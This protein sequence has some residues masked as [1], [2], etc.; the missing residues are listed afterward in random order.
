MSGKEF[1]PCLGHPWAQSL[2]CC[3]QAGEQFV[4]LKEGDTDLPIPLE[5]HPSLDPSNLLEWLQSASDVKRGTE[6]PGIS[7]APPSAVQ[8]LDEELNSQGCSQKSL[9]VEVSLGNSSS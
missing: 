7:S 2:H 8:V 4:A 9:Q 5:S 1:F 3:R 6:P